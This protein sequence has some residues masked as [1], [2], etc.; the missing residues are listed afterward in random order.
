MRAEMNRF[1]PYLQTK[2]RIDQLGSI[3]H[4]TDKIDLILMGGTLTARSLQYQI[5]FVKG[6]LDGM[7]G[8]VANTLQEAQN[9]NETSCHRCIGMTFE[10]RPDQ[11]N[12]E[13][14]DMILNLGGTRVELG[15]QSVFDLPLERSGRGHCVQE[16]VDATLRAKDAGLKVSYHLMPGIPGSDIEMDERSAIATLTDERFMPDMVKIYPTLVIEGTELYEMWKNGEYEPLSSIEAAELVARIK[17]KV[18]P[19]VRI[20]RVQRDIPSP[21]ISQGVKRSNLRQMA[22]KIL[23]EEGSK[24]NCIRCRE[25]GHRSREGHPIPDPD[26]VKLVRRDYKASQGDEVFL[27]YESDDGTLVGYTRLRSPSVELHREEVVDS[28]LLRELKV[29]GPM[30]PIGK[31]LVDRWQHK[32]FGRRLL[33]ESEEIAI[34]EFDKDNISVTSGI[35]VREYYR[36]NGYRKVGP[37]MQ[38]DLRKN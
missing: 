14:V 13:E 31:D 16:T 8:V 30:V 10:T 25:I 21:L 17:K 20:Q 23:K 36:K 1:D 2:N 24:C 6:C 11:L 18:P 28:L 9:T 4:P 37:Y 38:K 5:D 3:G 15:V 33:E 35:G 34:E 19:W 7:N 12:Y 29:F 22:Q 27:S 32:G 26:D